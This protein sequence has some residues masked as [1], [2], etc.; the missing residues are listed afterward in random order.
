MPST[1]CKTE[2][3]VIKAMHS[4]ERGSAARHQ[5]MAVVPAC[6]G[7]T[8]RMSDCG[9]ACYTSPFAV[10]GGCAVFVMSLCDSILVFRAQRAKWIVVRIDIPSLCETIRN[11]WPPLRA[12]R[13]SKVVN[14]LIKR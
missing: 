14:S 3:D 11:K 9:L 6:G 1:P 4:A 13:M 5:G 2:D 7:L 12:M 10:C 8:C